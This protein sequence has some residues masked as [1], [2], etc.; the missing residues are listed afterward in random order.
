MDKTLEIVRAAQLENLAKMFKHAIE[1]GT[2]IEVADMIDLVR[3]ALL[4]KY[5]DMDLADF[6]AASQGLRRRADEQK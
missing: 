3:D 5:P 1:T 4:E 6:E 2:E